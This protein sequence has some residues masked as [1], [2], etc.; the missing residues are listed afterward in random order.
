[1]F[2]KAL[3]TL[4]LPEDPLWKT[5]PMLAFKHKLFMAPDP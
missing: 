5:N 2:K 3:E 4:E 1:M